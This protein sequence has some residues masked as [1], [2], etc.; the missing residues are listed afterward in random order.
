MADLTVRL[1]LSV[2]QRQLVADLQAQ[3][4]QVRRDLET[5]TKAIVAGDR[6]LS[7]VDGWSI[8]IEADALVLT[9]PTA[10]DV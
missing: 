9:P 4:A 7:A 2:G 8:V 1:P 10:P 3:A 5:V 6:T